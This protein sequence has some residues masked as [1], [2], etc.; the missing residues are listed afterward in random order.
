MTKVKIQAG[1]W[2]VVCDGGKAIILQNHGDEKFP[3]LRTK[4][5]YEHAVPLTR[6]IGTASP[7][8][9]QPS[10][11]T[12][13]SAVE[14]AAWHTQEERSFLE[15]LVRRLDKAIAA[16]EVRDLII[17]AAPRALGVLRQVYSHAVRKAIRLELGKDYVRMPISEIEMQLAG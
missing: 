16:G 2:I 10:V 5:T 1:A 3:D 9:V 15:N 8:R 12:A 13:R 7:G 11:G 4:E 6:E 17:I 14:Q